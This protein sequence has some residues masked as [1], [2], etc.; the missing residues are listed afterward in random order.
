MILGL[1]I[2][3]LAMVI[4]SKVYPSVVL[5]VC[6]GIIAATHPTLVHYSCQM[7]RENSF[8]FFNCLS[9]VF[10]INYI[11]TL[12]PQDIFASSF[13]VTSACLCR[14]EAFEVLVIL[15]ILLFLNWKVNYRIK[16]KH[17]FI[18]VSGCA[19]SFLAISMVIGIPLS[20]YSSAIQEEISVKS[21]YDIF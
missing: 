8:L 11:K 2:I 20:Y 19:L 18:F 3:C 6:V 7:L 10:F 4:S 16:T 15:C 9:I 14:Y 21:L 12:H 1:G 5:T 17:A 13:F